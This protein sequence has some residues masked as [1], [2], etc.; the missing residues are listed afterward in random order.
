QHNAYKLVIFDKEVPNIN[1]ESIAKILQEKGSHSIM[2]YDNLTEI[3]NEEKQ[4]FD[5]I[6]INAINKQDLEKL[7]SQYM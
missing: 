4:L 7:V 1:L 6:S 5:K 3:S 2:F